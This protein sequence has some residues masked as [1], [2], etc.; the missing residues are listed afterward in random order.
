MYTTYQ[1]KIAVPKSKILSLS[2]PELIAYT[3]SIS[4]DV[5]ELTDL[6]KRFLALE[7]RFLA[8]T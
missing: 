6:G 1:S 7:K 5:Q 3:C 4:E 8:T 2:R